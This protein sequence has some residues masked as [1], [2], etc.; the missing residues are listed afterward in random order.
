M[1]VLLATSSTPCGTGPIREAGDVLTLTPDGYRGETS[2][3]VSLC[4]LHHDAFD[5]SLVSF[6]ER[7]QIQVSSSALAR[8][9]ERKILGGQKQFQACL[10]PV[11]LL[12]AD[13]RDYPDPRFIARGREA[14]SWRS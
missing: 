9:G 4:S 6:N 8:L 14:R 1:R 7:Y 2:N 12:P 5:K 10:K 13:T 11:I 3:G